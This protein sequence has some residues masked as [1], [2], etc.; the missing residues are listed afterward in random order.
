MGDDADAVP[1]ARRQSAVS[2]T[3]LRQRRLIVFSTGW[4]CCGA[5]VRLTLQQAKQRV[6]VM[7][8]AWYSSM[9]YSG[10][11][12]SASRLIPTLVRRATPMAT[13][14]AGAVDGGD[15]RQSAYSLRHQR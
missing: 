13:A 4:H 8:A 14:A 2:V 5:T 15:H 7:V 1:I 6:L 9:H 10:G 11:L 12:D 3:A